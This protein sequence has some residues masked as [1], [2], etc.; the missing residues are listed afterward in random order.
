MCIRDSA[1][2]EA[3]ITSELRQQSRT[4][5]YR[6]FLLRQAAGLGGGQLRVA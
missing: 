6:A 3:G 5:L 1:A 4:R 2:A